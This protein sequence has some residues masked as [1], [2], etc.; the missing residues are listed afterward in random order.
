MLPIRSDKEISLYDHLYNRSVYDSADY[1]VSKGK[2]A[3]IFVKREDLWNYSLK[4]SILLQSSS[5]PLILEFGVWKGASINFFSK[6]IEKAEIVGF[7]SFEGLEEDWSGFAFAKGT[8][9]LKGV[10]PKVGQN[11]RL[12]KGLFED[13]LPYFRNHLG[14]REIA[15]LH[16]DADTYKPT[17][18]VLES[19]RDNISIGTIIIFDEYFGYPNWREHEFKAWQEVVDRYH[20]RY[21]YIAYS[22]Q[23]V[24]IEIIS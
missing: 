3:I 16:M 1:I 11:V 14:K 2:E 10:T 22:S 9:N 20:I 12:I 23:Q 21:R 13:S 8:F 6:S 17:K 19:L 5:A 15:I 18:F 4:R 7:D 24:A